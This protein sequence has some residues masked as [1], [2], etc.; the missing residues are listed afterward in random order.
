MPIKESKIFTSVAEGLNTLADGVKIHSSE[1]GFP[2]TL[3]EV[4]LRKQQQYL[5]DLRNGYEKAQA[6]AD[7]KS[8]EYNALLKTAETT[9]ASAQR[10]LQGYYGLKSITLKDF[11]FQPPKTGGKK[12]HREPKK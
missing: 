1:S 3:K 6:L 12:G 5:E 4:E 10:S 2:S 9:L 8:A 11:G 7:K